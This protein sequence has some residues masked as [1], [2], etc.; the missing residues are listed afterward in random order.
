MKEPPA[1]INPVVLSSLGEV[2][3]QDMEEL[4]SRLDRMMELLRSSGWAPNSKKT[5]PLFSFMQLAALCGVSKDL[6][7][8]RLTQAA[9]R[10]LPAGRPIKDVDPEQTSDR[11]VWT[12]A[13]ARQW[14]SAI[15][16]VYRRKPGQAACVITVCLFKGGVSKSISSVSLAQGL[17]LRGGKVLVIDL[18]PQ[19]SA[20]TLLGVSEAPTEHTMLPVFLP[21]ISAQQKEDMRLRARILAEESGTAYEDPCADDDYTQPRSSIRPSIQPTYWDGV[22]LVAA[23]RELFS[24]EFYL[25]SRQMRSQQGSTDGKGFRFWSVMR[26]A[27]QDVLED[28][29]YIIVDTP[30]ALSYSVVNSLYASDGI[31]MPLPPEGIDV[32]S[33]AVWWR[34]Y[35]ELTSAIPK[36]DRRSFRF[37]SVLPTK[38]DRSKGKVE[39]T[40]AML[41]LI[42]RTYGTMMVPV[43]VPMSA[44]VS[45]AGSALETVY[46][47]SRYV[48]SAKTYARARLAFDAVADHIERTARKACWGEINRED[49]EEPLKRRASRVASGSAGSGSKAQPK[50][51]KSARERASAQDKAQG[52]AQ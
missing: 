31:L 29:D 36:E 50:T 3:F 45:S 1:E 48:G 39:V 47:I 12:L 52:G 9:E 22:D 25:P 37:V 23:N 40:E 28:Y 35:L 21:P 14:I 15:R 43:E 26:T 24:A 13:E 49:G 6:M 7:A 2:T 34:M 10:G 46:D 18:D 30:P 38:V 32:A 17:S 5:A 19:A 42:R 8:S 44:A 33:S 51:H 4:D 27:L 41:N 16:P 11:K 20:S